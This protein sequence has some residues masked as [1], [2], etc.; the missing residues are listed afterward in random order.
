MKRV[1]MLVAAIPALAALQCACESV[2]TLVFG[3]ADAAPDA[4]EDAQSPSADGGLDGCAAP[5]ATPYICC[6]TV[7]CVGCTTGQC[8]DCTS[9]C[10]QPNFC[11]AN[12]NNNNIMCRS[13]TCVP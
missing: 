4:D 1:A 2:P 9:K 5:G 8:L 6:G 12:R 10:T 3:R 7:A 11:C 13:T